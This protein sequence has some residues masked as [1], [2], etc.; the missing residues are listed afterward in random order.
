MRQRG[1]TVVPI[2]EDLNSDEFFANDFLNVDA[3]EEEIGANLDR[4]G[5]AYLSGSERLKRRALSWFG[6]ARP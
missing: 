2:E 6:R 3:E 4:S 5:T 1:T